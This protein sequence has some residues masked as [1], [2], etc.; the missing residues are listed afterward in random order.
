MTNAIA[1]MRPHILH[2]YKDASYDIKKRETVYHIIINI[3]DRDPGQ[4]KP[5]N[6]MLSVSHK[7]IVITPANWSRFM[8]ELISPDWKKIT[9]V[10][11]PEEVRIAIRK[12]FTKKE[13]WKHYVTGR[14]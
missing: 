5:Y 3:E 1:R 14:S 2:I 9:F 10:D 12:E 8:M 6:W 7:D 13:P 11:M 4:K